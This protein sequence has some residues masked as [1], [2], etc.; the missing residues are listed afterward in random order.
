MAWDTQERSRQKVFSQKLGK[1]EAKE[2]RKKEAEEVP[3][4]QG[5]KT[6]NSEL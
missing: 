3:L 4:R 6:E 2:E 1:L 5:G